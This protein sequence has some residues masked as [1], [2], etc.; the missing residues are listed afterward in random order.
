MYAS[1]N[2]AK[3]TKDCLCLFVCPTG[4]TDTETGQIDMGLCLDGCRLCVDACPSH[5]IYLV[6]DNYPEPAPKNPELSEL[7]LKLGENSYK[8]E[9]AVRAFSEGAETPAAKKLAEALR[10]SFRIAAEDCVREAGFMLPQS[11]AVKQ[12]LENAAEDCSPE[13]KDEIKELLG[14]LADN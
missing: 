11:R 4:A 10:L 14:R 13:M 7:L 12:L 5:A 6:M 1:R 2:I 8:Q 9:I 3:C